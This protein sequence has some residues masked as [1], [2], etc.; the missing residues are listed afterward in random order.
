M[1]LSME[2]QRI[3]AQIEEHLAAADPDLAA[4]LSSFGRSGADHVLRLS[5]ARVAVSAAALVGVAVLS[6]LLYALVPFHAAGDRT[7]TGR[8]QPATRAVTVSST[9][10]SPGPRIASPSA[11]PQHIIRQP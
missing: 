2:E 1:A 4:R 3:L 5:H 9:P 8:H 7:V 11:G 10:A 6:I